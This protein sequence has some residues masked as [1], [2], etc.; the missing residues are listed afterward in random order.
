[1]PNEV[2][3]IL[4]ETLKV[5][6]A[7]MQRLHLLIQRGDGDTDVAQDQLSVCHEE[8]VRLSVLLSEKICE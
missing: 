7:E 4:I 6:D 1:M 2:H 3:D 8:M 5:L